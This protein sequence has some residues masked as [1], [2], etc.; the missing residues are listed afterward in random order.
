M[1]EVCVCVFVYYAV[2][3]CSVLFCSRT[4]Q[5]RPAAAQFEVYSLVKAPGPQQKAIQSKDAK[6]K[7]QRI[8]AVTKLSKSTQR[9][10]KRELEL[11]HMN[12]PQWYTTSRS[13]KK[14]WP[15]VHIPEPRTLLGRTRHRDSWEAQDA[16]GRPDHWSNSCICCAEIAPAS[17]GGDDGRDSA[18]CQT[19]TWP[20]CVVS[21]VCVSAC[22]FN[23]CSR[24]VIEGCVCRLRGMLV[25]LVALC[26]C[27]CLLLVSF[28]MFC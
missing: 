21:F 4:G 26:V 20:L 3:V 24:L 10:G 2:C 23:V 1:I 25:V 18:G 19:T 6:T 11:T 5:N 9:R 22:L 17:M 7:T 27:V 15:C 8:A 16:S 13:P 12:P 28:L 14:K